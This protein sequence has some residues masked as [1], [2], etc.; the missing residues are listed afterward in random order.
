MHRRRGLL[1]WSLHQAEHGAHVLV[2][3]VL[4]VVDSVSGLYLAIPLVG[5]GPGLQR[6]GLR[7]H[8]G[9]PCTAA[10]VISYLTV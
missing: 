4:E 9:G 7:R 8:G 2:E 5:A 1:G 10:F 6:S 3:P